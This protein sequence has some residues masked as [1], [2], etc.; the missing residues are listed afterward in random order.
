MEGTA[1]TI[2]GI[3]SRRNLLLSLAESC[4]G[5]L[6]AASITNVPGASACF[7][8]SYVVYSRKAK[9][10]V[11]GIP[12][13]VLQKCGTVSELTAIAM[14]EGALSASGSDIACAVT[15]VAGPSKN[16]EG[17]E[18]GEAYVACT[19]KGGNRVSRSYR[20]EGDRDQI[21]GHCVRVA[22]AM[23]LECLKEENLY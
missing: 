21:R 17:N 16:P 12:A 7:D 5:G 6:L 2:V 8:R 20:F 9:E 10:E 11:L 23:I 1:E 19:L 15:G 3:L 18:V 4:T 13:E 14:A 22:L